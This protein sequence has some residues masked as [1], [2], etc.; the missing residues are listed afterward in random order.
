M[1]N[2]RK[3]KTLAAMGKRV[4]AVKLP[5][6]PAKPNFF[7]KPWCSLVA[8]T[9]QYSV[10][11]GFGDLKT[12]SDAFDLYADSDKTDEVRTKRLAKDAWALLGEANRLKISVAVE[13]E[14]METF[15][16]R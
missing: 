5:P 16:C 15:F 8:A 1:A 3:A 12:I 6:K 11:M 2:K 13:Q 7:S 14:N 4:R 10:Q 9:L